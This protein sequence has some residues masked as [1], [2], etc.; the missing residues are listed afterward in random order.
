MFRCAIDVSSQS[1]PQPRNQHPFVRLDGA[2]G[3]KHW[4]CCNIDFY[5]FRDK[6]T[7]AGSVAIPNTVGDTALLPMLVAKLLFGELLKPRQWLGI[8]LLILGFLV[9]AWFSRS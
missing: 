8:G 4:R 2:G 3:L 7:I 9:P 5:L 1:R 6:P